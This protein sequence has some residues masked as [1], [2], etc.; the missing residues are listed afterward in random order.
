MWFMG[1]YKFDETFFVF[2][3][4]FDAIEIFLVFEVALLNFV[5]DFLLWFERL[6]CLGGE[7]VGQRFCLF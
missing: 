3:G 4:L 1:P 7:E 6:E 5:E 2:D